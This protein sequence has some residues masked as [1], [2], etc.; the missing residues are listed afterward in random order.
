MESSRRPI[1]T[2]CLVWNVT[3]IKDSSRCI[4]RIW[5]Y[6]GFK[7]LSHTLSHLIPAKPCE[8]KNIHSQGEA[9]AEGQ[10][11]SDRAR[12]HTL[13]FCLSGLNTSQYIPILKNIII[14]SSIVQ[15]TR[16]TY[17]EEEE[18]AAK[19]E[20]VNGREESFWI[21]QIVHTLLWLHHCPLC[22]FLSERR[23]LLVP[24]E[25]VA[26]KPVYDLKGQPQG[27]AVLWLLSSEWLFQW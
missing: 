7:K 12:T 17:Q 4:P 26:V 23:E 14:G 10:M 6:W 20:G 21:F 18:A 2:P 3:V 24:V 5:C 8:G 13:I 1:L 22:S 19:R 25:T 11:E 15:C 9:T 16:E 27:Q